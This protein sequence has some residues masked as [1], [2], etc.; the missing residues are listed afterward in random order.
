MGV[1]FAHTSSLM[2]GSVG[3]FS[4]SYSSDL[5]VVLHCDFKVDSLDDL[6]IVPNFKGHV[7]K[8][9]I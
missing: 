7:Y 6:I 4:I 9:S 5:S 8:L 3:L 1:L 2:C